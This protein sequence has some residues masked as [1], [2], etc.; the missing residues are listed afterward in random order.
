MITVRDA[1]YSDIDWIFEQCEAFAKFYGSRISLAANP[2]YGKKFLES[3]VDNHFIKVGEIDGRL[4]GFIAGLVSPHHFNP[5][6][7]Q[8][9]ELLWWVPEQDRGSGVGA[10]LFEEFMIYGETKCN[11]ITFTLEHNSPV[12]D[13]FLLKRGFQMT[14]RAYLKEC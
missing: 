11:W 6:I 3:L 13:S 10:E 7:I 5:D 2:E 12:K 9:T 8:L 1:F 14:E 4:A